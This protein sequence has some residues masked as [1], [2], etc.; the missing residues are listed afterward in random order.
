M[1]QHHESGAAVELGDATNPAG[2]GEQS[3]DVECPQKGGGCDNSGGVVREAAQTGPTAQASPSIAQAPSSSEEML[4]L[5]AAA[6]PE[7]HV[8]AK[9]EV[10]S[11]SLQR[12]L[13]EFSDY[14]ATLARDPRADKP[15]KNSY[16]QWKVEGTH[17]HLR[18]LSNMRTAESLR[19]FD[20]VGQ[21]DA[22]KA[23]SMAKTASL[24]F[25]AVQPEK[26]TPR[27]IAVPCSQRVWRWAGWTKC[28][29]PVIAVH[30]G[31]WYPSKYNPD[32]YMRCVMYTINQALHRWAGPGVHRGVVLLST[33][34]NL[35]SIKPNA[36]RCLLALAVLLQEVYAGRFA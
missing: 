24:W 11:A 16:I 1:P 29:Y 22:Q 35:D 5:A 25:A 27:I 12:L 31:D 9:N 6:A 10:V 8:Q 7:G 28:G 23:L 19:L 4:A 21:G 17:A 14:I 18:V 13:Q 15:P 20:T 34:M 32:A 36:T 26:V 33:E 3:V 30:G 2:A